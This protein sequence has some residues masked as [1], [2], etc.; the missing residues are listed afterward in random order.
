MYQAK[1]SS[2]E[3]KNQANRFAACRQGSNGITELVAPPRLPSSTSS[4]W[5]RS[6]RNL[7]RALD[8]FVGRRGFPKL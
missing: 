4:W 6:G 8:L 1:S 5:V 7:H 2:K 3:L